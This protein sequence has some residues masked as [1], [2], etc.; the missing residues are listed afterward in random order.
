MIKKLNISLLDALMQILKLSR[1]YYL[2]LLFFIIKFVMTI[3]ILHTT[4]NIIFIQKRSGHSS[5]TARMVSMG[6]EAT[7]RTKSNLRYS[8]LR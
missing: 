6:I 7:A 4:V 2:Q 3:I 8:I 1:T 5:M